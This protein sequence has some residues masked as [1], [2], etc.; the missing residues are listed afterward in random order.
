MAQRLSDLVGH[1][2]TVLTTDGKQYM[3]VLRGFDQMANV[4][5]EECVERVWAADRP[6]QD[7][8]CQVMLVRGDI[9]SV[10]GKVQGPCDV[11]T[12]APLPPIFPGSI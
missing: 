2:V 10:I 8:D 9:I 1:S 5:L 3:G 4:M 11:T 12:A 6:F 7:I